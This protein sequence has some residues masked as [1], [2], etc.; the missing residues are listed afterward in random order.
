M[1]IPQKLALCGSLSFFLIHTFNLS[2]DSGS[3]AI[4]GLLLGIVLSF[5]RIGV[6]AGLG[7]EEEGAGFHGLSLG[8]EIPLILYCTGIVLA[9][10]WRFVGRGDAS[11]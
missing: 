10:R 2:G 7:E 8:W 11:I 9:R 6:A 5:A 4:E 3:E 1:P